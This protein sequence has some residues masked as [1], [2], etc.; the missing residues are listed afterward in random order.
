MAAPNRFLALWRR[1][2]ANRSWATPQREA[3]AFAW[4]HFT[5]GARPLQKS[6]RAAA[7]R[8]VGLFAVLEDSPG[9]GLAYPIAVLHVFLPVQRAGL[10]AMIPDS[11]RGLPAGIFSW[12]RF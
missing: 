12:F 7:A 6:S 11:G 8:P 3:P 5:R 1:T 9:M 10:P 4:S 2:S